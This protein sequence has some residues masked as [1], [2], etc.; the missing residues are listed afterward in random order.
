VIVNRLRPSEEVDKS[1]EGRQL[2]ANDL[3]SFNVT[4]EIHAF[5]IVDGDNTACSAASTTAQP[6]MGTYYHP[7]KH[8]QYFF[9]ICNFLMIYGNAGERR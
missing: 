4:G 5:N 3:F 8:R 6:S 1:V 2:A 7:D 9:I